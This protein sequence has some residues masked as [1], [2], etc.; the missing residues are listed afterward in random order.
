MHISEA[1]APGLDDV[2][3][4][5]RAAFGTDVEAGLAW[6]DAHAVGYVLFTAMRMENATLAGLGHD[7]GTAGGGAGEPGARYWRCADPGGSGAA[8]GVGF[9][10]SLGRA[11]YRITSTG[12]LA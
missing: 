7:P 6:G 8:Q 1:Q 12:H 10:A 11:C 2:L 9:D 4:V 5:E 3:A